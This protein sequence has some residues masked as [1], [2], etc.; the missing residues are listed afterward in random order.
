M[1]ARTRKRVRSRRPMR[2]SDVRPRS[3]TTRFARIRSVGR[4]EPHHALVAHVVA[5]GC[6]ALVVDQHVRGRAERE[7]E[8]GR[9]RRR[10]RAM[11]ARELFVG[12]QR[13]SRRRRHGHGR[14]QRGDESR[15][16]SN[17]PPNMSH[18]PKIPAPRR[19]VQPS[20]FE[21]GDALD[22]MRLREHVD[23]ADLLQNPAGLDEF[24]GV[25]CERGGVAGDV[26]DAL[27][28][29]FDDAAHDFL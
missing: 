16:H 21:H 22:V 5:A 20:A 11:V 25:G 13:G 27:G 12:E 17:D 9:D 3:S 18:R 15:E 4:A 1:L 29:A 2:A 7:S 8:P 24:G 14:Q 10:R 28:R 26:D 6:F 19:R 23:G